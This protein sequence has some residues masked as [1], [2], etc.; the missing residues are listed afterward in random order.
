MATAI[1]KR[2][3]KVSENMKASE[4]LATEAGILPGMI[5][6]DV[7]TGYI[8][9]VSAATVFGQQVLVADRDEL[10]HKNIDVAWPD[11]DS[12]HAVRPREGEF[13]NVMV[14]TA[15]ALVVGTVLVSAGAGGALTI[16]S[17]AGTQNALFTSDEVLTTS[18]TE[19]VRCVRI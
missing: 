2:R 8:K 6:T 14:V 7:T 4:G 13:V 1:G 9:S 10:L 3:I 19:L 15:Q 16:G 5:L 18:G 11:G 12:M 17:G